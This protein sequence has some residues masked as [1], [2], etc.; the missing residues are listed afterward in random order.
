MLA[1]LALYHSTVSLGFLS[2]DD[3]DYVLN[4]PYIE[5]PDGAALKFILTKSYAANY[6]PANLLSY[7][8]DV[9]VAHGKSAPAIH[10]SNVLWHGFVVWMLYLLAFTIRAEVFTAT[11]A[12]LLFLLH[13]THVEVVAWI[14]SRKDLVATGFAV[15]AMTGYLRYR[16]ELKGRVKWLWYAGSAAAFL[17]A[18]GA[19]QSVI[20]LPVVMLAWDFLVERRRDLW[21][22]ADKLVYGAITIFFGWMTWHAQPATNQH[23]ALFVL[24]LTELTNL[25]LLTG[26]GQYALFRPA[27]DPALSALGLKIG[28]IALAAACWGVPLLLAWARQPVRA[29]MSLW[30]LI[31][32]IP[33][34][35][36]SFLIPI[37]DRYLFLPSVG[38]CWLLADLIGG[39]VRG[40]QEAARAK[41]K[42]NPLFARLGFGIA[43]CLAGV[44]GLKTWSYVA[45]WSDPRSVWY[46]ASLK[47]KSAQVNQFLGEIY[48]EA[49]NRVDAF[50]KAGTPLE[51]TNELRMAEVVAEPGQFAG[52]IA[53]WTN[54]TGQRTNSLAYRERLWSLAWEQFEL[55]L[56]RRGTLSTPNLFMNRGRLLISQ[57]ESK[58]AIPEFEAALRFA[59]FSNYD[60]VRQETSIHAMRAI[61][62]AYWHLRDYRQ[63]ERWFMDAQVL[64]RQSGKAWIPS[65][66]QEVERVKKLAEAQPVVK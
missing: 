36:L 12:A 31:Q 32:M 35:V 40:L 59:R 7:A 13:P 3:P 27:P 22:L 34:M 2:V 66:D 19:K 30:V 60:V 39:L 15:L 5:K 62:T 20:L 58:R 28:F 61:G 43:I 64:Q 37:T 21:M 16:R 47:T 11:L 17:V 38:V 23:P 10:L 18:S 25:W 63:A 1:N 50:V 41:A 51:V 26:F 54:S 53:E 52:L 65:L 24:A 57:N 48:Q 49:G 6:A 55:S 8:L 9:A 14:S 33:P 29:V 56:A 44:W 42:S 45:E 4:N 46:G